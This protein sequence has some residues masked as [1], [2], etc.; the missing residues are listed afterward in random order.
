[1]R[2]ARRAPGGPLNG[3][4]RRASGAAGAAFGHAWPP[5]PVGVSPADSW[6]RR[7]LLRYSYPDDPDADHPGPHSAYAL[8]PLGFIGD[9]F[10]ALLN[11]GIVGQQPDQHDLV[12]DPVDP[13]LVVADG[14]TYRCGSDYPVFH[15]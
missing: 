8:L 5:V 15:G 6:L 7:P 3:I 14:N 2:A 9:G 4:A 13:G 12:A 11:W 1:L 10:E